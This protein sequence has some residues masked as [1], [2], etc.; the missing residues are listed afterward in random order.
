MPTDRRPAPGPTPSRPP[1]R[2]GGGGLVLWL[3]RAGVLVALLLAL[4]PQWRSLE[5]MGQRRAALL[6]DKS[7]EV[8]VGVSWPFR[9]SGQGLANGLELARDRINAD[10]L[11]SGPKVRLDLRDD[12]DDWRLGHDIAL[13]FAATP[14]MAAVIGYDDESV[15]VRASQIFERT[16][17]LHILININ[18]QAITRHDAKYVIRTVQTTD[19][20]ARY[21]ARF[22][23]DK[24]AG[25]RY[26]LVWRDDAYGRDLLYQYL[27]EQ[28][29]H[30][31][32]LVYQWPFP[33][34]TQ[35]F[36]EAANR[37]TLIEADVILFW[38]NDS[39]IVRFL[40][41]R[42]EVGVTTPVVVASDL[43]SAILA[44]GGEALEGVTFLSLYNRADPAPENQDF[45]ARYQARFGR[46]PDTAAAQGYDALMMLAAAA[47]D[48]HSLNPLDL[49]YHLRFRPPWRGAN[50]FY[51]F[52]ETGDL[53]DKPL[54]AVV[55]RAGSDG[56]PADP[57]D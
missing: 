14:E 35:D 4:A 27:I 13:D 9:S 20:I 11:A 44:E 21:L 53:N 15:A 52:D 28:E 6:N 17:L 54:H 46:P 45:V 39:E 30:D 10:N 22:P 18:N 51:S 7:D 57:P 29:S 38:G 50:G 40:R 33:P 34:G 8:L 47:R 36:R 55:G 3:I 49:S 23:A 26:A 2:T 31:G 12:N 1:A 56:A 16:G 41:K 25:K 5:S 19:E 42:R 24:P 32:R 43:S 37:L 48:T